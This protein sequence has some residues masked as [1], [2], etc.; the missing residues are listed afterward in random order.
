MRFATAGRKLVVHARDLSESISLRVAFPRAVLASTEGTVVRARAGLRQI[1]ADERRSPDNRNWT[2]IVA[3]V[4]LGAGLVAVM[5]AYR[6]RR[7]NS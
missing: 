3:G 6:S 1:I 2:A 7:R 4:A 5:L